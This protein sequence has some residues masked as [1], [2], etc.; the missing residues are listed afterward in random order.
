MGICAFYIFDG[1][2]CIKEKRV[3]FLLQQQQPIRR[4]LYQEKHD[5]FISTGEM[6]S[7][8]KNVV[9]GSDHVQPI[10]YIINTFHE[11]IES[12]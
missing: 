12:S 3:L 1:Q 11:V 2:K 8:V 10:L 4:V 9:H 5:W 6:S 7:I